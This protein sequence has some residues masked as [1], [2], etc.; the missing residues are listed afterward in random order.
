MKLK[1]IIL[2]LT[3]TNLV[4]SQKIKNITLGNWHA[5]L[6][7]NDRLVLPFNLKISNLKK[8]EIAVINAAEEIQLTK[9]RFQSDSIHAYFPEMDGK[10][11]FKVDEFGKYLRGYWLDNRKHKNIKIP[12]SAYFSN[13]PRFSFPASNFITQPFVIDGRWEVKFSPDQKDE[14]NALGIFKTNGNTISG[15]FQTETGDYR[16]LEGN[17]SGGNFALSSFDG[18]Q[19]YVFTGEIKGDSINGIFYSGSKYRTTWTALRNENASLRN[20]D[21]LSYL[22]SK[23]QPFVFNHAKQL[24]GKPFLF[25]SA[26]YQN[27]VVIIQIMGTWCPNCL[28]ETKVLKELYNDLH[29]SGLE[30]ISVCYE[31]DIE[32][33]KQL[34]KLKDFKKRSKIPY[35]ILYGGL[36]N[37]ELASSDFGM[38][39]Q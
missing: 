10:L 26:N 14:S 23:N 24:N 6:A 34:K 9:I 2:F 37:K 16:F 31:A 20:P 7:L 19:A 28:D 39:N 3:I 30:I 21:S 15:T 17:I 18:A 11:V 36:A 35:T 27:K 33:K 29:T 38:L 4:Y 13:D 1:F 12:L 25:S 22:I 5:E 32:Q 8:F